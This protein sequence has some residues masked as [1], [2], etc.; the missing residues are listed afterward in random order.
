MFHTYISIDS[1]VCVYIKCICILYDTALW[2]QYIGGKGQPTYYVRMYTIIVLQH[3]LISKIITTNY[4]FV[5][6]GNC[7]FNFFL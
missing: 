2:G 7:D 1:Y 5:F 6:E 4:M 3:V